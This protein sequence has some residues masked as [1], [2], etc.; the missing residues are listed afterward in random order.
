MGL[1]GGQAST[2]KIIMNYVQ[3]VGKDLRHTLILFDC[4]LCSRSPKHSF[5][6]VVLLLGKPLVK[7]LQ[8]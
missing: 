7:K 6:V 1:L 4:E 2:K 5:V 8:I 3:G